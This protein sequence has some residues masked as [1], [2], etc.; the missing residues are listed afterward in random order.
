MNTGI[1][2]SRGFTHRLNI[3]PPAS[4]QNYDKNSSSQNDKENMGCVGNG[5]LSGIVSDTE[6]SPF[7]QHV[8]PNKQNSTNSSKVRNCILKPLLIE[9]N[10][11]L[12]DVFLKVF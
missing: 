3:N 12:F 4:P 11:F 9:I 7:T 8:S 1:S 10:F 6:V 5:S 2:R